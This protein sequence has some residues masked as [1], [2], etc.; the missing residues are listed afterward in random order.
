MLP[1]GFQL[2][3]AFGFDKAFRN[4]YGRVIIKPHSGTLAARMHSTITI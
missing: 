2:L 1:C 3:G 4:A